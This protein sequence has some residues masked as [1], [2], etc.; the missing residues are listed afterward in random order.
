MFDRGAHLAA[1]LADLPA[2][3]W[4]VSRLALQDD[5]EL[6]EEEHKG[7]PLLPGNTHSPFGIAAGATFET[8]GSQKEL[9]ISG[10]NR[11]SPS[12]WG[13][14]LCRVKKKATR[15]GNQDAL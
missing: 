2:P 4:A 9:W 13:P 3:A 6:L 14:P 5:A 8:D 1:R 15:T 12:G 11:Y 10:V 7:T